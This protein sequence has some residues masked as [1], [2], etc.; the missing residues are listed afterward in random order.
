[1]KEISFKSIKTEYFVDT[2][3][4]KQ[5]VKKKIEKILLLSGRQHYKSHEHNNRKIRLERHRNHNCFNDLKIKE[6]SGK[7]GFSADYGKNYNSDEHKT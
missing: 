5:L 1:M 6:F 2:K 7:I 4:S 3:F